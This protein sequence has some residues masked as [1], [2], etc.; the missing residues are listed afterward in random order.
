MIINKKITIFYTFN[1][2][3]IAK[4]NFHQSVKPYSQFALEQVDL[5]VIKPKY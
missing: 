3:T 1:I 4:K 5:H 2:Q